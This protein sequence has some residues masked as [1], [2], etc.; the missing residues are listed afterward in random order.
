MSCRPTLSFAE[1][2]LAHEYFAKILDRRNIDINDSIN[3]ALLRELRRYRGENEL[4]HLK[5]WMLTVTLDT[6]SI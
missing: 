4:R 6:I 2:S 5:R 1:N 3:G